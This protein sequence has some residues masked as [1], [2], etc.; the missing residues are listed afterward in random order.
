MEGGR[1]PTVRVGCRLYLS[2]PNALYEA[3]PAS[4]FE[5]PFLMK[6]P[7]TKKG[8]TTWFILITNFYAFLSGETFHWEDIVGKQ[9]TW[10]QV[11]A[12]RGEYT[13]SITKEHN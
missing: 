13:R 12:E 6:S 7:F 3:A 8:E 11:W 2:R 4:P 5:A 10:K 1:A 9:K